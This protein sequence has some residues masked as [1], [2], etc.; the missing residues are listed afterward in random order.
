MTAMQAV[1]SMHSRITKSDAIELL[2]QMR[3]DA[4]MNPRKYG[5]V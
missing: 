5:I 3:N 2:A 4:A 1:Q